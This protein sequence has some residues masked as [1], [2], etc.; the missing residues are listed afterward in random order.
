M[1]A[2]TTFPTW[3]NCHFQEKMLPCSVKNDTAV[4]TYKV[5]LLFLALGALWACEN[6]AY[7]VSGGVDSEITL[8]SD[9]V[10]LP[11]A[12]IGPLTPKQLLGED[13]DILD[14]LSGEWICDSGEVEGWEWKASEEG[15]KKYWTIEP[16]GEAEYKSV[17]PNQELHMYGLNYMA[18]YP[19]I[20]TDYPWAVFC[21]DA[22]VTDGNATYYLT[23]TKEGKLLQ[24]YY[25][26]SK[27]VASVTYY[28]KK[29]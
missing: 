23:L 14:A 29:K 18:N 15:I 16:N 12:N 7:D 9:Q 3:I 8:F 25:Y 21:K 13:S 4:K 11:I 17:A 2:A 22:E 26:P 19:I 20:D 27:Y 1:S 24:Y 6:M 5:Y 10:S 28:V